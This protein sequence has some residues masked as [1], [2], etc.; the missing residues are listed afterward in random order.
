MANQPIVGPKTRRSAST[1]GGALSIILVWVVTDVLGY[2]MPDYV[3]GAFTIVF[4][5]VAERIGD[6]E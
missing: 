6:P 1:V 4:M 3:V 5:T 2:P